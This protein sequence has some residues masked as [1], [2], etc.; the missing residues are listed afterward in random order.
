MT[1][2]NKKLYRSETNKVLAGVCGGLAEY[3][4]IDPTLVRVA[5]IVFTVLTGGGIIIYPLMW[6]LIPS[7]S[8]ASGSSEKTMNKNIEEMKEKASEVLKGDKK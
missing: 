8:D 2:E 4:D 1:K 6:L 7:E 5:F 3:F